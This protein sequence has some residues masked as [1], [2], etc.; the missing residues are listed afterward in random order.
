MS[1]C[2]PVSRGR[3]S[4]HSNSKRLSNSSAMVAACEKV[5]QSGTRPL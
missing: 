5:I 3:S 4:S 1:F 2:A